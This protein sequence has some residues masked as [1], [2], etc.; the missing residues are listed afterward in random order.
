M[1]AWKPKYTIEKVLDE[2]H[3]YKT[4]IDPVSHQFLMLSSI[5]S[6]LVHISKQIEEIHNESNAAGLDN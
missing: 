1:E 4:A 2:Q 3:K 5:Q 6:G